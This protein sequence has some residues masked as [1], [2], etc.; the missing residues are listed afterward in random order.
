MRNH[1]DNHMKNRKGFGE[2][3]S[4]ILKRDLETI[5]D[6]IL[7]MSADVASV[8][9]DISLMKELITATVTYN[10]NGGSSV[11]PETVTFGHTA[12]E[13]EDP[14]KDGYVFDGWYV[15]AELTTIFDFSEAIT[16]NITLYA[17]WTEEA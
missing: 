14:T 10:S 13:P 6:Q 5:K 9:A 2:D 12:T 16:A 15:D 3:N 1:R 4:Y 17:K 11:S 7:E 8:K